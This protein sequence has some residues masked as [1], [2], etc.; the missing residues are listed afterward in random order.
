V[1]LKGIVGGEGDVQA[2]VEEDV[3]GVAF[4]GEEEGVV[5]E[6]THSNTNLIQ[7]E[8]RLGGGGVLQVLKDWYLTKE[9]SMGDGVRS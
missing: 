5:G 2:P 3:E 7:V 4:V 1:E 8:S 9:D 6:W